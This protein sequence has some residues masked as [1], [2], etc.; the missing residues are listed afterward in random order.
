M[1]SKSNHKALFKSLLA[2][3]IAVAALSSPSLSAYASAPSD[4]YYY[5]PAPHDYIE[6]HWVDNS[7][8]EIEFKIQRLNED[9]SSWKDIE[10]V[11]ANR[12]SWSQTGYNRDLTKN[13]RVVAVTLSGNKASV[14]VRLVGTKDTLEVYQ[15]VPGIRAPKTYTKKSVTS[16]QNITFSELQD[17]TPADPS[18]GKATRVSTF[19]DIK[20]KEADSNDAFLSSP[21]YETRPQI[22]N[23]LAQDEPEHSGSHK[24]YGYSNYGPNANN[25]GRTV[26]QKHW[27]NFESTRNVTVQVQ[28]LNSA[29]LS[30]PINMSDVEIHPAPLSMTLVDNNTLEIELPGSSDVARHYRVSMNRSA[31]DDEVTGRAGTIIESPLFIFVNPVHQ[32]PASAPEGQIKEFENGALVAIG[33]GIHLPNSRYQHYGPDANE[34][35]REVYAPG[36]A[37]LHYGIFIKN[38]IADMKLWG[39]AIYS[40]EMFIVYDDTSTGYTGSDETRTPWARTRAIANNPWGIED[41]YW[42]THFY[43]EGNN[44]SKVTFEG[45][46]NIGGRMATAFKSSTAELLNHKDVGYGGGT[47]Q[48]G[49]GESIVYRGNLL[50]NDDDI[51]YIHETYTM[52]QNTSFNEHNGPSFQF[53][54][55]VNTKAA[56]SKTYNHTVWSSNRR[57]ETTFGKNHGVFNSRLQ[58]GQLEQHLGGHFENFEFWGKEVILFNLQLWNDRQGDLTG[59][60][61]LLSDKTFK[62]FEIHETPYLPSVIKG[63]E[64]KTTDNVGYVRFFHFDNVKFEGTPLKNLNDRGLFEYNEY[65]LPHTFTFFSL[66]DAIA[67]PLAGNAPVGQ[68][69]QFKANVNGKFVQADESLPVSLSPLTANEA[70]ASQGFEVVDAGNGYI[71]LRAANGYY[72]KADPNRY[73]YVYTQPDLVRGDTDTQEI[74]D[75]AKFVWVDVDASNFAL[76]SKSMGLYVKA[77]AHSGPARPLYAAASRIGSWEQFSLDDSVAGITPPSGFTQLV[78]KHNQCLEVAKSKLDNGDNIQQWACSDMPT[79]HWQMIAQDDGFYQIKNQNSGKCMEVRA[80]SKAEGGNIQQWNCSLGENKLFTLDDVGDGY[81]RLVNKHSGL[82]VDTEGSDTAGG[83]NVIQANCSTSDTQKLKFQ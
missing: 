34:Q 36:D 2:K 39:R 51:T 50:T 10:S 69:I 62:D 11:P 65:V 31:W 1:I 67:Q 53:G 37:Y 49:S 63:I 72:V 7:Q 58:L 52:E 38:P 83:T 64:D 20:V 81:F 76:W 82:C 13:L 35:A 79:K 30:G 4:V 23:F 66:P 45:F 8:D 74:T 21:T 40:D 24:P 3:S 27:T 33:A 78:F 28:L 17:Q 77:E 44:A 60:T 9:D 46:T 71:A 54:W 70:A 68:T 56:Q 22:R 41:R 18:Q 59:L 19:F 57:D 16:G 25:P 14:P 5:N 75:E 47:Y 55:S 48:A 73:G 42:S 26:H 15:E 80:W 43:V 12:T 6:L 32:A 61:S 29:A